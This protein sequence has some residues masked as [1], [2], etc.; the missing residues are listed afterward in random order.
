[1]IGI[2]I[3][4]ISELIGGRWP[5]PDNGYQKGGR[6]MTISRKVIGIAIVDFSVLFVS[7]CDVRAPNAGYQ[8]FGTQSFPDDD[9]RGGGGG[10]HH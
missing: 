4:L 8:T 7:A 5:Y 6:K 3:S 10:G 2:S 9:D 1:L